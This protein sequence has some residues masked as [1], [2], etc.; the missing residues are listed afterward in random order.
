MRGFWFCLLL[1]LSYESHE[2]LVLLLLLLILRLLVSG[3][4][5][6]RQTSVCCNFYGTEMASS[7]T[8]LVRRSLSIVRKRAQTLQE[9]IGN[10]E[11]LPCR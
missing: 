3:S 6:S 9:K 8:G 4:C 5:S 11:E 7:D 2:L 10:D 1:T